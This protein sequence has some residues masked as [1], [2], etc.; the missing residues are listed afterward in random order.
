MPALHRDPRIERQLC[1]RLAANRWPEGFRCPRCDGRRAWRLTRR[2]RVFGCFACGCQTSVTAGTLLHGTRVPLDVVFDAAERALEPGRTARELSVDTGLRYGT[3]LRLL[4]RLR[5]ALQLLPPTLV[6]PT[7]ACGWAL[8]CTPPGIPAVVRSHQQGRRG[9]DVLLR[10]SL[11]IDS[12]RAW[13]V[14]SGAPSL[15][16]RRPDDVETTRAA[17]HWQLLVQQVLN[18][19][20]RGVSARWVMSYVGAMVASWQRDLS[21]DQLF[22][23]AAQVRVRRFE[24]LRS[25]PPTS[26]FWIGWPRTGYFGWHDPLPERA[27]APSLTAWRRLSPRPTRAARPPPPPPAPRSRPRP[28]PEPAPAAAPGPGW[29]RLAETS[30]RSR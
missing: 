11:T 6:G 24:Q 17:R 26:D 2:P 21:V 4:H 7:R 18:Q 5:G 14:S 22:R 30:G 3:T 15:W 9:S 28:P 16:V 25:N 13:V 10:A 20:H 19:R 29:D 8:P 27:P 12:H 1:D 23:A